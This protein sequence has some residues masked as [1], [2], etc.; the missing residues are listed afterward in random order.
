MFHRLEPVGKNNAP[1]FA[2]NTIPLLRPK[3]LINS[4]LSGNTFPL[5][6][7]SFLTKINF[8]V[9]LAINGNLTESFKTAV[10]VTI[11]FRVDVKAVAGY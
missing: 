6:A 7:V 10:H 5:A 9:T 8:S 3:L 11:I 2:G 1:V 4:P